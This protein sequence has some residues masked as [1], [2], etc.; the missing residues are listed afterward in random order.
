MARTRMTSRD[1]FQLG[2]E[3][4][5]RAATGK[6][7]TWREVKALSTREYLARKD[8]VDSF[9]RGQAAGAAKREVVKEG[10]DDE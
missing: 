9:I 1:Q 8:E 5:R 4:G 6:P 10:T 2:F 7:L 3:A